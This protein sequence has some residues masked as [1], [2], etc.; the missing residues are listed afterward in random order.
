MANI[1]GR[2]LCAVIAFASAATA[3]GAAAQRVAFNGNVVP[4]DSVLA[5]SHAFG[6][7]RVS[8]KPV[9]ARQTAFAFTLTNDTSQGTQFL[10]VKNG[11]VEHDLL[12]HRPGRYHYLLRDA[13][14]VRDSGV[15]DVKLDES[16]T[17]AWSDEEGMVFTYD[18]GTL[19]PAD[20]PMNPMYF[21]ASQVSFTEEYTLGQP[22]IMSDEFTVAKN[23]TLYLF[24]Q[25]LKPLS[26]NLLAIDVFRVRGGKQQFLETFEY[27][28]DPSSLTAIVPYTFR[29]DGNYVFKVF[30]EDDVWIENGTVT[31][32]FR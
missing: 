19:E 12:F 10:S 16:N 23:G 8:F 24:V 3:P 9:D 28:T 30:T 20:D 32:K 11:L 1:N 22:E 18:E 14:T 21:I 26:T 15:I 4:A 5:V 6:F 2:L 27:E 13:E 7:V 31:V 25:N 17:T 29:K